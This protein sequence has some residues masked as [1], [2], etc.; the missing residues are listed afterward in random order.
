MRSLF[1]VWRPVQLFYAINFVLND[2]ENTLNSSDLVII[3]DFT[4]AESYYE[5]VNKLNIFKI[6]LF[7]SLD[8]DLSLI[9]KVSYVFFPG[10][11]LSYK[12]G[13]DFDYRYNHIFAF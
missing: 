8:T 4:D 1:I 13:V 5:K 11:Y 10:H 3:D 7:T 6:V 2:V 9:E 12:F